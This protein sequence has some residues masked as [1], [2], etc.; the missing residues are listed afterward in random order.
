ME[1]V[2]AIDFGTASVSAAVAEKHTTGK[3]FVCD[4]WRYPY[5][6]SDG[7]NANRTV[8][9]SSKKI[10]SD[11]FKFYPKIE[12]IA[13]SFSGPFCFQKTVKEE[14]IRESLDLAISEEEFT[15][16]LL[17][18]ENRHQENLKLVSYDT[19]E[20]KVNGYAVAS[21]VGH[22]G[23]SLEVETGLLFVS[24]HLKNHF[25][26]MKDIFFPASNFAFFSDSLVLKKTILRFFSPKKEFAVLDIG[27]NASFFAD[28]MFL[29]GLCP[30][31]K[32]IRKCLSV[33]FSGHLDYPYER[34]AKKILDNH[35][36]VLKEIISEKR[37][38]QIFLTGGGANVPSFENV[39]RESVF[40][41]VK[42]LEAQSFD[43][44]FS[45]RN[46]LSGGQDAVL[47]AL[48]CNYV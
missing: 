48:I 46:S 33:F 34:F 29:F 37:F 1:N 28:S 14:F 26:E 45:K 20:I 18:L 41:E 19:L 13:V 2:L 43:G 47:T 7:Q 30:I 38:N 23:E 9:T 25:E 15:N 32:K 4:V 3:F 42:K 36:N 17:S 44:F 22:K 21:P 11:A 27:G 16:T 40:A 5:D 35:S 12:N 39:V 8:L 31:E 24:P 10:F 6:S